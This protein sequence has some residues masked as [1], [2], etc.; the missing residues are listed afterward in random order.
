[1]ND[2]LH[3]LPIWQMG[4]V[5]FA[6]TYL[7]AGGIVIIITALAKG[8]RARIFKQVSAGLLPPLGILFGLLVVF[9]IGE[10]LSNLQ[11]ANLEV[12]RKQARS[13]RWFCSPPAFRENQKHTFA[14]WSGAMLTK[15]FRLSGPRWRNS[16]HLCRSRRRH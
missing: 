1:M 12:D 7:V 14:L 8:E 4:V 9:C 2:W 5:V 3:T 15:L 13:G 6:V 16:P 11:H 10:V